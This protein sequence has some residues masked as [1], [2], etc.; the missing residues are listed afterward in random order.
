M[1]LRQYLSIMGFGT[2]VAL[3]SWVI[4]LTAID[5]FTAGNLAFFVF[6]VTLGSGI[7]GLFTIIGTLLRVARMG[8]D[9]L[10]LAVTRSLRQGVLLSLLLTGSLGLM[11]AGYFGTPVLIL[12]IGALGALEFLFLYLED[13]SQPSEG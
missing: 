3:V 7:A 13:R 11:G 12:A 1:N 5:P 9:H 10:G 6:Y 8:E 2:A 4:V